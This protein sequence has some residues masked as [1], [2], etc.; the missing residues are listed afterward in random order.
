[1]PGLD[2][3]GPMGQGPMTGRKMGR[4]A[5]FGANLKS[6]TD[7]ENKNPDEEPIENLPGRGFGYGWGGGFGR[8]RGSGFGRGRGGRGRGMGWRNRFRGGD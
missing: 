4:C 6:Q 1:M 8:G 3:R 2:K 5:N 7:S